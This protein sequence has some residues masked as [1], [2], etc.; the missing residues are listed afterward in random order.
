MT[1]DISHKKYESSFSWKYFPTCLTTF[2]LPWFITQSRTRL[3]WLSSSSS[4]DQAFQVPMQYRS[5]QHWTFLSPAGT[6]TAGRHFH[7]DSPLHSFWSYFSALPSSIVDTYQ[8]GG[9][10]LSRSYLFAYS[11][12]SWGSHGKNAEVF[13]HSLLQ[14]AT[15]YLNSL[16]WP[17]CL[18]WPCMEWLILSSSYTRPWSV[19][20]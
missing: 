19:C 6:S 17:V 15:F 1:H 11:D 18:G 12:C 14:W 20:S 4:M 3:K 10:Y 16:P 2:N 8:T 9:A 5:L 7:F 13:C